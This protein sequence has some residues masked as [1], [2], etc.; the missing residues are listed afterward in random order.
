[1]KNV[2]IVIDDLVFLKDKAKIEITDAALKKAEFCKNKEQN[3]Y[4]EYYSNKRNG[5]EGIFSVLKRRYQ[6]DHIPVRGLLRKKMWIGFKI[7]A[8]NIMN[9][10]NV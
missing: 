8:M 9:L 3:E 2:F 10:V 6:I 4:M 1:M 7:G 5:I